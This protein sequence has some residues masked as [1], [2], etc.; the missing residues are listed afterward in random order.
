LNFAG[1]RLSDGG[2]GRGSDRFAWFL[3]AM[4]AALGA[5]LAVL[6]LAY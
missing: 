4:G 1:G 6:G 3:L 5:A 2:S